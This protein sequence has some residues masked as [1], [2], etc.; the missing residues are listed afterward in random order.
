MT[1]VAA[2]RFG[3]QLPCDEMTLLHVALSA[4]VVLV[5]VCACPTIPAR[6][7]ARR[8]IIALIRCLG[9]GFVSP[10]PLDDTAPRGPHRR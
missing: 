5:F 8:R 10:D 1:F 6:S 3:G 9:K 2:V 4:T 7:S